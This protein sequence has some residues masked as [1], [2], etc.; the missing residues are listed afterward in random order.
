MHTQPTLIYIL[1]NIHLLQPGRGI[2]QQAAG[3]SVRICQQDLST[4]SVNRRQ[5]DLS[6][7]VNSICQQAAGGIGRQAAG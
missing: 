3:G 4:G 5:G 7:S 6:G 2:C 1:A